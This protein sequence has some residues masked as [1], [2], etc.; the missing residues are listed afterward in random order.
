[1]VADGEVTTSGWLE[2]NKRAAMAFYGLMFNQWG[3]A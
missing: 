3:A 1:M 2:H